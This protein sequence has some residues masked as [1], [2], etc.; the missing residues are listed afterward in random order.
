VALHTGEAQLRNGDDFGPTLSGPPA[1]GASPEAARRCARPPPPPSW[2]TPSA[3]AVPSTSGDPPPQGHRPPRG[4]AGP[5]P[6]P[7][8]EPA[9]ALSFRL[10]PTLAGEE[11]YACVGRAAERHVL[12]EA[13]ADAA[14]SLGGA[15]LVYSSARA[16]CSTGP[17]AGGRTS[18]INVQVN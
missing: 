15:R 7:S 1:Y 18:A 5:R 11:P 10:P 16:L 3:M 17:G 12:E 6:A 9:A 8:A 13:R 14:M 4:G 2:P